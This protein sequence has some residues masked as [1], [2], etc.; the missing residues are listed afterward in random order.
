[1]SFQAKKHKNEAHLQWQT[2]SEI[3][4][5][6]FEIER[7][8]DGKQWHYLGEVMSKAVQRQLPTIPIPT[9]SLSQYQYV[10]A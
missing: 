2:N 10:P 4:S 6:S 5:H 7:S 9:P 8:R 3:N 1:M